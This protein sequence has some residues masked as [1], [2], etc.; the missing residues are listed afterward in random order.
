MTG[1]I[2]AGGKYKRMGS[3]KSFLVINGERLIDKTLALMKE[4][5]DEIIV[6]TNEPLE[7]LSLDAQIVT[8]IY[9]GKG[10][11]GG[12]Y[13]GLFHARCDYSF[14]VACDMP[15][16]D[17]KF[18]AYMIS[19]SHHHD[20]IVPVTPEGYQPLHAVYSKKCLPNIKNLIDQNKLKITTFYKGLNVHLISHE[21]VKSFDPQVKMF[22]NVNSADDLQKITH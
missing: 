12:I 21:A 5:F 20:I 4:M 8:D 3:N 10:S 16:L 9:K 15:Y 2:L 19:E 13:T 17:R 14:V 7:Y 6:V 1:I 11:L 22:F 18:I